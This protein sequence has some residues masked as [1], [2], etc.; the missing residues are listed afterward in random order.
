MI[1]FFHHPQNFFISLFINSLYA[2]FID[3]VAI[4]N[5][6]SAM[7]INKTLTLGI[8]SNSGMILSNP[9]ENVS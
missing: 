2:N 6:I 9:S 3:T 5:K 1:V 7:K 8:V 4:I